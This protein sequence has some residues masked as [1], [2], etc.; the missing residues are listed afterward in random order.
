MVEVYLEGSDLIELVVSKLK[1]FLGEVSLPMKVI[2][3]SIWSYRIGQLI[4]QFK[5]NYTVREQ[6]RKAY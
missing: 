6:I 4:K 1:L 2:A 5:N 3:S